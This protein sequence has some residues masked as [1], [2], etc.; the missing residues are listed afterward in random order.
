VSAWLCVI[1]D[2]RRLCA[3]AGAGIG[4][5]SDLLVAQARAAAEAGIDLLQVRESAFGA[6]AL[7]DLTR[8]MMAAVAGSRLRV[9]VND[10]LDVALAAEA[11]GVHLRAESLKADS[12]RARFSRPL[13]IGRS[14]HEVEEVRMSGQVDYLLAGTVFPSMS[15]R[16]GAPTCGLEGFQAMARGTSVP[17]LALGGVTV[18][19]WPALRKAGAAGVAGIG[20]FI[21]ERLTTVRDLLTHCC[22]V[23]QA[24]DTAQVVT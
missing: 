12:I 5:A 17:V 7:T 13:C 24:V 11:H 8:R 23:R 20:L 1:T 10:R 4:E 19:A 16:P 6:R 18:A 9:V 14:V 21:P 3:A 2:S 22:A 15:K